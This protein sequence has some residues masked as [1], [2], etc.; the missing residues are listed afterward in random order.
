M[1]APSATTCN[2]TSQQSK[3]HLNDPHLVLAL[4]RRASS[5]SMWPKD[6]MLDIQSKA[7]Q[8]PVIKENHSK[9]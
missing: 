8:S 2:V 7:L 1:R 9:L 5:I 3:R 4:H 6:E